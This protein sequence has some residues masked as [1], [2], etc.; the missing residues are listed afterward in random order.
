MGASYSVAHPSKVSSNVVQ[1]MSAAAYSKYPYAPHVKFQFDV[2][3]KFKDYEGK[4]EYY[5]FGRMLGHGGLCF[6]IPDTDT[7]AQA[8]L[9]VSE[10]DAYHG[11]MRWYILVKKTNKWKPKSE[12]DVQ[13]SK[14]AWH[15]GTVLHMAHKFAQVFKSYHALFNNC[16]AWKKKVVA[17][18]RENGPPKNLMRPNCLED[19]IRQCKKEG[20]ALEVFLQD[21]DVQTAE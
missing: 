20:V 7:I 12:A 14:H 9:V 10:L 8:E 1:S 3:E 4:V 2:W 6:R 13:I 19:L 5:L 15:A 11:Q 21:I 16:N 17:Y 18:L